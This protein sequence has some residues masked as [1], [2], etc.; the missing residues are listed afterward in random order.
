MR[1]HRHGLG[2]VSVRANGLG[3]I[4]PAIAHPCRSIGLL[5]RIAQIFQK[6]MPGPLVNDCGNVPLAFEQGNERLAVLGP[7]DD[8]PARVGRI[9]VS[10]VEQNLPAS[11][12]DAQLFPEYIHHITPVREKFR[13]A[14]WCVLIGPEFSSR[15]SLLY[16]CEPIRINDLR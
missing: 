10:G 3:C 8:S 9:V 11:V 2:C 1:I 13:R 6:E 14:G 4:P 12:V 7:E 15:F 16:R 5:R